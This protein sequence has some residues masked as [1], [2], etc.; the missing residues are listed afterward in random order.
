MLPTKFLLALAAVAGVDGLMRPRRAQFQPSS[1][2]AAT[3]TE[4]LFVSDYLPDRYALAQNLS[5]VE[6]D[7]WEHP[8]HAGLLTVDAPTSSNTFL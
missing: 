8:S 1:A 4:P 2:S 3:A 6:I 5:R 7:G